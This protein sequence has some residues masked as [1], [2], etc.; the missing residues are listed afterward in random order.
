[1]KL[2]RCNVL[3]IITAFSMALTAPQLSAQTF[4]MALGDAAGGT[5]W[6]L[7]KTFA[8][9]LSDKTGGK[10]KVD[11]FPNGQLGTEQDTVNNAAIGLLDFSVLAINNVTPFSPTVGLLTM[12]YVIQSAEEARVL[13]QGDI[14]KELVENTIRDAGVRI[15]GW[16]YSGFRVLTNSKR[17]VKTPEDL[18]G[19]VIR[20]PRNEIM[21]A[22][23]QA[24]GINPT[25]MAWSETFTGLQQGVVDGQDNPYITISA[26][27]FNEVQKYV[28]NIRYIF[29]MEP[30]IISES[31]FQE[32]SPEMQ[33]AILEAGQEA[34]VHSFEFLQNTEDRIK[35]ELVA[36]GMEIS[37]PADNEKAW[38][39]SVTTV[40]WPKFYNSIGGKEK[41]DNALEQLGR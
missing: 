14:G 8:E 32:Q 37:E 35:K 31:V 22:S 20:V 1:M 13:T 7:G 17:P 16:A 28:T 21:I 38:I 39:E 11:L 26:M 25:P 29:S 12:P 18:K 36:K 10:A 19:L 4:K 34:T 27:K 6:E 9:K 3:A 41:L 5:Q 33:K 24:L 30:L 2:I 40:V 15:I 23:Y